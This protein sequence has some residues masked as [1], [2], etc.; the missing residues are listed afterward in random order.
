M[1]AALYPGLM[2]AA[3]EMFAAVL[4]LSLVILAALIFDPLQL[5]NW[6]SGQREEPAV[7]E[8]EWRYQQNQER[9]RKT[10]EVDR[11]LDKVAHGGLSSLSNSERT[12]LEKLSREL[13]GRGNAQP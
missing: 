11:L 10:A 4:A 8:R 2:A 9:N 5:L 6:P 13:Y 1:A 3:P 7:E 12:R